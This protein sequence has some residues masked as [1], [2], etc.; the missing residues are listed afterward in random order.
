VRESLA[1]DAFGTSDRASVPVVLG[2]DEDK[3]VGSVTGL[4]TSRGWHVAAFM[5]D[6][7]KPL[8]CV[9]VDRLAAGARLSPGFVSLERDALLDSDGIHWHQRALLREISILESGT[10]SGTPARRLR[11]CW[12]RRSRRSRREPIALAE[13]VIHHGRGERIVRHGIGE[14]LAVR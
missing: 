2:H 8:A 6:A 13:E 7:S 3:V 10:F 14:V 1:S 12:R 9:A 4:V 11:A 5:L